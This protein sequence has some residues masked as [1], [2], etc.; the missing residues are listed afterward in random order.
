MVAP[1]PGWPGPAAGAAPLSLQPGPPQQP[2]VVGWPPGALPG[3]AAGGHAAAR[4]APGQAWALTRAPSAAP[5]RPA[6]APHSLPRSGAAA[7]ETKA[8]LQSS[9]NSSFSASPAPPRPAA[10]PRAAGPSAGAR[11]REA[12]L[13]PARKVSAGKILAWSR[14]GDTA[15]KCPC[16]AGRTSITS[17][18]RQ[19]QTP[20]PTWGAGSTQSRQRCSGACV[21]AYT[22]R[23]GM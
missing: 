11:D 10:P 7:G 13:A 21:C 18:T 17:Y 9:S 5:D 8:A 22:P 20:H 19:P 16:P 3:A 6:G 2:V 14:R 23:L 1:T 12:G 15:R 4:R